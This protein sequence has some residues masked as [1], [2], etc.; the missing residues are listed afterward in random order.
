MFPTLMAI[1][2][3]AGAFALPQESGVPA[4]ARAAIEAANKAWMPAM[5]ARDVQAIVAP[6]AGDGVFDTATGTV[7]SG[8]DAIARLL[9][10]RFAQTTGTVT[11]GDLVQDGLTRQGTLIYEWG[12]AKWTVVAAGK[13]PTQ[14]S[15]RYLT[16]WRQSG[17]G[18]WEIVRNLSLPD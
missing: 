14:A 6:Y 1:F 4:D 12:H 11:G 16:V 7:A 17:A 13:P 8:R 5:K 9:R 18:R 2:L 3:A 10:D 15:G